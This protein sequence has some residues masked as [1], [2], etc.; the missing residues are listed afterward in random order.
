MEIRFFGPR[1]SEPVVRGTPSTA[2][3]DPRPFDVSKVVR[4]PS[5]VAPAMPAQQSSRRIEDRE[6]LR[7]SEAFGMHGGLASGDEVAWR[8]RRHS[9]QPIST[10]AKWIVKREV[11]SLVWRGQVL[12]PLFQFESPEMCLRKVVR[13]VLVDLNA[14]FDDWEMAAWFAQPNCFLRNE[15]PVDVVNVD[16]AGLLHAAR[17]DRFVARG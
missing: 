14:V 1:H 12:L 6:F 16:D 9:D 11:L 5:R 3:V 17:A 4:L 8:L 15:R 10:L 7:M 13:D 2:V